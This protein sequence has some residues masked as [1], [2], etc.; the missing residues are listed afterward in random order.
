M[1]QNALRRAK[2]SPKS[3]FICLFCSKHP[4]LARP[5]STTLSTWKNRN[6]TSTAEPALASQSLLNEI[7]KDVKETVSCRKEKETKHPKEPVPAK[8]AAHVKDIK[9]KRRLALRERK[10]KKEKEKKDKRVTYKPNVVRKARA[11]DAASAGGVEGMSLA[12]ALGKR[13]KERN[14][15]EM[16]PDNASIEGLSPLPI[17]YLRLTF[18]SSN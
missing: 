15:L 11:R 16:D 1:L 2:L 18:R 10:A 5:L 8:D 6:P 13:P 14:M 12:T 7:R 4:T 9:H 3:P 17:I